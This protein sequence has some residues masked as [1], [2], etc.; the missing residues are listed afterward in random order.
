MKN[1]YLIMDEHLC[2]LNSE[3]G[4][5]PS[6]SLLDVSVQ[7]ALDQSGWDEDAFYSRG[8]LYD[9]STVAGKGCDTAL[10]DW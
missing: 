5:V 10:F 3:L 6:L 2:L 1:S 8:G 7:E 9:W 4:K